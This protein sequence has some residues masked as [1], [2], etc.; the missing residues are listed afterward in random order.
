MGECNKRQYQTDLFQ[1]DIAFSLR[2]LGLHL[3]LRRAQHIFY[4]NSI[5][6]GWI[7]HHHVCNCAD[8]LAVLYNR[9]ARHSADDAAREGDKRWVG[10]LDLEGL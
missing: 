2:R 10:D 9:A 6:L 1:N 3:A 8:K 4:E 5:P 7:C